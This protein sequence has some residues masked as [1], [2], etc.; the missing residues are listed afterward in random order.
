MANRDERALR[1]ALIEQ[2]HREKVP[3][4]K[5][6]AKVGLAKERVHDILAARGLLS[7]SKP[8]PHAITT[9]IWDL[10]DKN[11]IRRAIYK[12]QREGARAALAAMLERQ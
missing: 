6:A 8:R 7:E 3:Q 10:D 11:R 1:D 4:I 12:R 5:I 9:T 2:M